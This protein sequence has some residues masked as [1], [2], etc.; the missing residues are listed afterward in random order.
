MDVLAILAI[1]GIIVGTIST[2]MV[3]REYFKQ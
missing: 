3:V 1:V 2:V